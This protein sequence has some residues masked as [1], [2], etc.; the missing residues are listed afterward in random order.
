MYE[1][2]I[3]ERKIAQRQQR[4]KILSLTLPFFYPSVLRFTLL[5]VL[6]CVA[7]LSMAA[8]KNPEYDGPAELPR[9]TVSSA[10]VDTPA[11]GSV[12]TVAAGGNLQTALNNARC[13]DVIELEA[14][15]RFSGQFTVPGKNCNI[16]NWIVVRTSAPESE[17][18][19]EGQRAT[20]CYAGI[21]SLQGRPKYSCANPRKVMAT[22]ENNGHG[23]GPFRLKNG[24]NYY[25]FVGL[26][27]T[28][29]AGISG[30]ARLFVGMGT[31]DHIVID[32]S[33]LHGAQRDETYIGVSLNGMTNVAVVDSYFTDF[34]CIAITGSCTDSHAIGGGVSNTQD[35]PF[36]IQDNF[37]EASGEG[38]LFGG[39]PATKSPSDIEIVGNHFWKPWQW[40]PG[41]PQF[42]GASNG[43]PF[44]VKNHLELK[45]ALRVLVD[46]NL[47]E[48]N[49]GGFS[50]SG[51]S[52]LLTPKNQRSGNKNVCPACTVTDI[53]VRYTYVSH[54]GAG[55]Q[56]ATSL[57]GDGAG[58]AGQAGA[59]WS[60]HD[61]VFDDL[62]PKY[63]GAGTAFEI[64]NNWPHN[65]VNNVAINHVTAFPYAQAH[66]MVVGNVEANPEMYA[67]AVRNSLLITGRYPVWNAGWGPRSCAYHDVPVTSIS[68]CF[69]NS[70]FANNVLITSPPEFPP[71]MWPADNLFADTIDEVGFTDYNNGDGGNYE[72]LPGSPYQKK[73]T[74]GK[75]LGADVEGLNQ[76]LANVE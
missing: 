73:G 66:I 33:W 42:V 46:S 55:M 15:A 50:Q 29:A 39:G 31:A 53:T 49:W 35:G 13:G 24:A 76:A 54:A 68:K 28:R 20:P 44:I 71:D 19:A 3:S 8:A 21:A 12:I 22:V 63:V 60:I 52:I 70:S 30:T 11:T 41:N 5:T 59:R 51:Y 57:S 1:R 38:I 61:V 34:H 47:M 10:M 67:L 74:D 64:I 6:T 4:E 14:G 48:N 16:N 65:P 27:I 45:N 72:L 40:M 62:S 23:D 56:L 9:L 58:G 75:D 43:R 7:V 17:L 2:K 25:R 36:K 18:P 26:E 37:L 32:R 69:K